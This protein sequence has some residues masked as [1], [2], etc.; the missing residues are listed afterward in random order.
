[1]TA[2]PAAAPAPP[3]AA[4][5]STSGGLSS[6]ENALG[7]PK[8]ALAVGAAV[9]V[10]GIALFERHK[11]NAAKSSSSS[12]PDA[13]APTDMNGLPDWSVNL[14]EQTAQSGNPVPIP[15]SPGTPPPVAPPPPPRLHGGSPPR[16]PHPPTPAQPKPTAPPKSGGS[17]LTTHYT[18]Q[19]G[20]TLWGIAKRF[21]GNGEDYKEIYQENKAVIGSDP[22]LIRP[23]EHLLV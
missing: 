5:S 14:Y 19:R 6:L 12:N 20:D 11:K 18:V 9:L 15:T 8:R 17:K 1:M 2:A 7:G 13:G 16:S 10:G 3:P 21:L 4:S 22:N 23:G